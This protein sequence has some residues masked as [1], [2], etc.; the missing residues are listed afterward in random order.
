MGDLPPYVMRT[1]SRTNSGW[2]YYVRQ[3]GKL[4]RLRGKPGT[5]AFLAS[6]QEALCAVHQTKLKGTAKTWRWLC[7]LY[8]ASSEFEA[9]APATR[10]QRQRTMQSTWI[11]PLAPGSTYL[12]GDCPLSKFT[13]MAVRMLRDRKQ[14]TPEAANHRIKCIRSVFAWAIEMGHIE[15]A[16]PAREVRKLR[17]HN[18]DGHHTWT[19]AEVAKYRKRHAIGT[20]PRLALEILLFTGARRS[21]VVTFGRP[22]VQDG[23]LCWTEAKGRDRAPKERS[24]PILPELQ[25]ALAATP[26]TGTQTW[27]VTQYGRPFTTGGFGNWFREQCNA[28]GLTHCTAHGLRKS[29]ATIAAENGATD[30]QLMAIFGWETAKQVTR[31]TRKA[32]RRRLAL[33]AMHLLVASGDDPKP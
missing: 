9:L 6:Y 28:A 27:L 30:R 32:D 22:M 20:K 25:A 31:Y 3:H 7:Q 1:R 14:D 12:M 10:S 4:V 21:D 29:G 23:F 8:M 24:I 26:L 17:S 19:I 5:P 18:P 13:G 15:E 16:N 11:E 33:E 2:R